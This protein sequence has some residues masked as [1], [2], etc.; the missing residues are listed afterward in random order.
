MHAYPVRRYGLAI[1][2]VCGSVA[3]RYVL[4]SILTTLPFSACFVAVIL[5][6]RFC[7]LGP[8]VL[9]FATSFLACDYLFMSP[10][11]SV[12]KFTSVAEVVQ[13]LVSAGIAGLLSTLMLSVQASKEA[14]AIRQSMLESKTRVLHQLLRIQESEKQSAG[15]DLHDGVL[16]YVIGAKMMLDA[17]LDRRGGPT[18]DGE[19]Q[20]ASDSLE[21]AIVEARHMIRGMRTAP[22]DD[23]GLRGAIEDLVEQ[24]G[25]AG[26]EVGVAFADDMGDVPSEVRVVIYRIAQELL[27]NVRKH[28]GA[29]VAQLSLRRDPEALELVV[30]DDGCGFEATTLET[31]GFGLTGIRE[32]TAMVRGECRVESAAGRGTRV[33][34]RVPM[35]TDPQ[36]ATGR[37]GAAAPGEGTNPDVEFSL[38]R[39]R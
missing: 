30:E 21:R 12:L 36:A 22:L 4:G 23:L 6:A 3:V 18:V 16:Q 2:I 7:G 34:V 9:A 32:R 26:T 37:R 33:S 1:A 25:V 5:A 31:G 11:G 38:Q 29:T 39:P 14:L 27:A 10:R 17:T 19:L 13:V 35:A 15:Y 20:A 28:S 24:C 8:T